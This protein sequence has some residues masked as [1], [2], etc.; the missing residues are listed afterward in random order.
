MSSRIA[1]VTLPVRA[2]AAFRASSTSTAR[3]FILPRSAARP[4]ESVCQPV[5]V[6][7]IRCNSN[8]A[9][10]AKLYEFAQIKEIS[11]KPSKE[12]ILIGKF[13][14]DDPLFPGSI[15]DAMISRRPRARR[16]HGGLHPH[17]DQHSRQVSAGRLLPAGRRVRGP[18]RL[19]E[20]AD[21][22]R[23]DLLLQIRSEEQCSSTAGPAVWILECSGIPRQL[24]RLVKEWRRDR[25]AISWPGARTTGRE[26]WIGRH[27]PPPIGL[28]PDT[29]QCLSTKGNSSPQLE[30]LE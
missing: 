15:S 30:C 25:E 3:K 5:F 14:L 10:N 6:Q 16:V 4:L 8:V 29:L 1:F 27:H 28:R 17:S 11:A 26:L 24:A 9:S 23:G 13:S 20:A 18:L 19:R 2:A 21:R 7:P 22:C 12:Q